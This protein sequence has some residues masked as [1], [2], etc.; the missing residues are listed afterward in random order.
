MG[1]QWDAGAHP[2]IMVRDAQT[3]EVLS[4]ARGGS[5]QIPSPG[6]EVDIVLSDGV[7]SSVRRVTVPR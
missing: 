6:H 4:L 1:I 2:M 7:K 3:G 5:V